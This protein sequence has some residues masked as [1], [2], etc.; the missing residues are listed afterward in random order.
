MYSM[1]GGS[2]PPLGNVPGMRWCHQTNRYY[3]VARQAHDRCSPSSGRVASL[4][5]VRTTPVEPNIVKSLPTRKRNRKASIECSICL[6]SAMDHKTDPRMRFVSLPCSHSFHLYCI[7][8]WL[9]K[10]SGSCPLC[11]IAVDTSMATAATCASLHR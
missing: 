9:L 5:T 3:A 1:N 8:K 11:R 4:E 10:R 6:R 7:E 2:G